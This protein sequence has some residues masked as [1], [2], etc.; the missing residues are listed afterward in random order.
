M[1]ALFL[2]VTATKWGAKQP[3][4][5]RSDE[6]SDLTFRGLCSCNHFQRYFQT[7]SSSHS[8]VLC[9][10]KGM[11]CTECKERNMFGT[12]RWGQDSP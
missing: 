10:E 12:S 9:L 6:R 5:Q 8:R 11:H 1:G 2:I 4:V 3:A 7:F